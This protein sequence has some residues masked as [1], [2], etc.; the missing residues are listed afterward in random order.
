MKSTLILFLTAASLAV[1]QIVRLEGPPRVSEASLAAHWRFDEGA[2]TAVADHSGNGNTGA[3][4]G[5]WSRGRFGSAGKFAASSTQEV[6][7]ASSASLNMGTSN[8]SVALWAKTG[9]AAASI[10]ASKYGAVGYFMGMDATGKF[11]GKVRD[12]STNIQVLGSAIADGKWH[13]LVMTVDRSDAATG[14]KLYLD[15]GFDVQGQQGAGSIDNTETFY[16]GRLASGYYLTGE[17]DDLRIWKRVLTIAEIKR[18]WTQSTVKAYT[19]SESPGEP[20]AF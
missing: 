10:L 4:D 8:F 15:G 2:G 17:I 9:T 20:L 14:L 3:F 5:S 16:I 7:V 1:A 19:G 11:Y 12:A 18:L 6:T 13:L